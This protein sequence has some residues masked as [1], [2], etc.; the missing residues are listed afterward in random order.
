[1][2]DDLFDRPSVG[3][4]AYYGLALSDAGKEAEFSSWRRTHD[5]EYVVFR[6][7]CDV[8]LIIRGIFGSIRAGHW[9]GSFWEF[10]H[11]GASLI[12]SDHA[13]RA[14]ISSWDGD[15]LCHPVVRARARGDRRCRS[16]FAR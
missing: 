11:E 13:F 16:R 7:E 3:R 9:Q 2:T 14:R 4:M 8:F 6:D 15:M 10:S 5:A 12:L 1:M